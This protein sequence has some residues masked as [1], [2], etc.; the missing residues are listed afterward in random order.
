MSVAQPVI[1]SFD[2]ASRRIFLK[3]GVSA[4][5]WIE[6]IYR[7]YIHERSVTEDFR[8]WFPFMVQAGNEPKGGGKFTPRYIT[9]LNG[10]RVVPYDENILITVT[11]EAIT[12]NAEVDPDPFDTTSRTQAVKLY[13]TPPAAEIV[14]DTEALEAIDHIS[15]NNQVTIDVVNGDSIAGFTGDPGLLGNG[16]FPVNNIADAHTIAE[17]NGF[18]TFY[19]RSNLTISGESLTDG[20]LMLGIGANVVRVTV[21]PSADVTNM[22]FAELT[23]T[24]EMDGNHL[25]RECLVDGVQNFSGIVHN[26][27]FTTAPF[28]LNGGV[29]N[30]FDCK[31]AVPGA[32]QRP[33]I[34]FDGQ[35]GDLAI[36][37]WV[38]G[39]ELVKKSNAAGAVTVDILS[40][41]IYTRVTCTAGT[42]TLRGEGTPVD[43]SAVGCSVDTS[44]LLN[45]ASVSAHVW[46]YERP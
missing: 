37:N 26:S 24:G 34:D 46:E 5:H 16:E 44:G 25:V 11:G 41:T 12:D 43:E 1:D 17:A 2:G 22:Q 30:L 4:F 42:I 33:Q 14:N 28:K 19:T 8:K 21:D 10:C 45:N 6:D 35:P 15:F 38:G 27:G 3:Q 29:T 39:I 23:L 18:T 32:N 13:I 9:L 7:E 31:S 40:G 20:Y 36:R